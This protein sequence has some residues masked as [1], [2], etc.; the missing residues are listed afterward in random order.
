MKL[1][2]LSTNNDF[3][4]QLCQ[5]LVVMGY[6]VTLIV[7]YDS[8]L[9]QLEANRA[10]MILFLLDKENEFMTKAVRY[11]SE[12]TIRVPYIFFIK[13]IANKIVSD[14][15]KYRPDNIIYEP[16]EPLKIENSINLTLYQQTQREG[17]Q[18]DGQ[19]HAGSQN[20]LQ[21][22]TDSIWAQPKHAFFKS[23]IEIIKIN[24]AEIKY[25]Q[26]DHVYVFLY[27][28]NKKIPLRAKLDTI[29]HYLPAANFQRIH[30][31]YLI[32]IDHITKVTSDLVFIDKIELPISRKFKKDLLA[33]MHIIS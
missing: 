19:V 27:T 25:L 1:V 4:T 12:D 18:S 10:D 16:F 26:S 8:F 32:N 13:N 31:R 28:E 23:G 6:E 29:E 11:L 20:G 14:I 2:L 3:T 17:P 7:D 24:F 30:M 22:Q 21:V 15:L 9:N 5:K 33:K